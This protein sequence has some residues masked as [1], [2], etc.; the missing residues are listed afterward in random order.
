[1]ISYN[2][3][4]Y[5]WYSVWYYTLS[6]LYMPCSRRGGW[7]SPKSACWCKRQRSWG[8]PTNGFWLAACIGTWRK[9]SRILRHSL[10]T[11]PLAWTQLTLSSSCKTFPSSRRWWFSQ[12]GAGGCRCRR[13]SA[14]GCGCSQCFHTDLHDH[15]CIHGNNSA[16]M[17]IWYKGIFTIQTSIRQG[18]RESRLRAAETRK[19]RS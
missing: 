2:N 17:K 7:A 15:I 4:W 3:N 12:D 14:T 8:W 11:C 19:R 6:S 5:L 1:M 13:P 10:S 18:L 16:E 9:M